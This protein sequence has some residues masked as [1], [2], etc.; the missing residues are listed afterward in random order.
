[1]DLDFTMMLFWA[2]PEQWVL[3]ICQLWFVSDFLPSIPKPTLWLLSQNFSRHLYLPRQAT[4]SPRSGHYLSVPVCTPNRYV[5][6]PVL[7]IGVTPLIPPGMSGSYFFFVMGEITHANTLILRDKQQ[8]SH[9]EDFNWGSW[10]TTI[11][12]VTVA[13]GALPVSTGKEL[14]WTLSCLSH[15]HWLRFCSLFTSRIM[16]EAN[17]IFL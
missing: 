13:K 1:M 12:L 9:G 10:A 7:P 4:R 2:W 5:D 6:V 8:L 3:E 16:C 14:Q 15:T 17:M 11:F